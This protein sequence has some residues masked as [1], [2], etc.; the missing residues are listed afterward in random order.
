MRQ[1]A[2]RGGGGGDDQRLMNAV[3]HQNLRFS[4]FLITISTNVVPNSD[5]ELVALA[6]WLADRAENLFHQ[7]HMLNG[8]VLKPAGSDNQDGQSFPDPVQ[9][10]SVRSRFSIEQGDTAQRGQVH[11]HVLMEV[12]H[13]YT[14]QVEGNAGTSADDRPVIGVHTN[15]YQMRQR[16]NAAI[17]EMDIDPHRRPPK[18][19]V[20]SRLLTRGTDNS[21]K[22]LTLQYI[23]KDVA[24]PD[25]GMHGQPRDLRADE[26]EAPEEDRQLA[27]GL[28]RAGDHT[29]IPDGSPPAQRRQ[30]RDD[31]GVGG[32]LT[33]PGS[34]PASPVFRAPG[35][36]IPNEPRYRAPA[37][38]PSVQY[39]T[40]T[41]AIGMP[42]N[43]RG[44]LPGR[45]N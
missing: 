33:P 45:Y 4:N 13:T 25:V 22:W 6:E 16:L 30:D 39:T 40:S 5:R 32:A 29:V 12:A 8:V 42:R 24:V 11:M 15:V 34:P 14:N 38:A 20:N 27:E 9:I 28:R 44:R 31:E 26:E 1:R 7:W 23:N 21:S 19:Y 43:T 37:V 3:Q 36:G 41:A 10:I 35:R 18:I 17:G 2:G